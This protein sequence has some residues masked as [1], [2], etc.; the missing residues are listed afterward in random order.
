MKEEKMSEMMNGPVPGD[1]FKYNAKTAEEVLSEKERAVTRARRPVRQSQAER[2]KKHK[3]AK[4]KNQLIIGGASLVLLLLIV[5][6]VG[7]LVYNGKFAPKTYIMDIKC[8][9]MTVEEAEE[10]IEKSAKNYSLEIIEHDGNVE[11]IHGK[12]ID[13]DVD[14]TGKLD[15]I[16]AGQKAAK[17]FVYLFTNNHYN[18]EASVTYDKAKLV[19]IIDGLK[20]CDVEGMVEP[21]DA[22]VAYDE[23]KQEYYI[24][25]GNAGSVIIRTSLDEAI[26][27]AVSSLTKSLD[28]VEAGCYK[29]QELKADDD[30]L[31]EQL[32]LVKKHGLIEVTLTFGEEKEVLD[33]TEISK[34]LLSGDGEAVS[35]D[36][37][38]VNEYVA[39]LAEKYDTINKDRTL[40]TAYGFDI[41]VEKGDYGWQMDQAAT[42]SKIAEAIKTGG[43]QVVE[44]VWTQ[45]AHAFGAEDWGKTY[46]EVNLTKQ[47][48]YYY[49]DGEVFVESDFVSGTVSKARSTPTGIYYIKYRKSP[50]ILRGINW[51]T[52][53]TYWMPFYD[54]CG[55]H[56][57]TWRSKFGGTIYYY[58]GSHGCL[59]MPFKEVKTIYENI[60]AGVPILIYKTEVE[61]V[62]VVPV[63]ETPWPSGYP[64]AKPTATP[65]ATETPVPT[66]VPVTAPPTAVPTAVPTPVV[67]VTPTDAPVVTDIPVI[68]D[69]PS[70]TDAVVTE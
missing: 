2:M 17:W 51:E 21:V 58:D 66:A 37:S 64:T 31:K 49:K 25:E 38:K 32:E 59:N 16:K 48:L 29:V 7:F 65:I 4:L 12:D 41:T 13:I 46:I 33:I 42:A 30:I 54:G 36:S 1:D 61:P 68:T 44:P 15:E 11:Y 56:D 8:A 45:S 18:I 19:E 3:K 5:Y 34:W 6:L 39:K 27:E 57:A 43:E 70:P 62:K 52:P 53:V 55:L 28:L 14:V 9:G 26:Y 40:H 63:H 23:A 10:A 67:T 20:A 50:S 47:H 35:V 22:F 60:E 69:I 24:D